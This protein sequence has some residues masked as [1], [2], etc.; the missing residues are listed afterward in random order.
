MNLSWTFDHYSDELKN[1]INAASSSNRNRALIFCAT[2]DEPHDTGSVYPADFDS[3]ISVCAANARGRRRAESR[4]TGDLMILGECI[5]ADGPS[6]FKQP[7]DLVS[8]SSVATALATGIASVLLVYAMC[9][10]PRE[11]D[12]QKFKERKMMLELF[13]RNMTSNQHNRDN[14]VDPYRLFGKKL[15]PGMERDWR[16]IFDLASYRGD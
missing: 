4:K 1:A 2:S 10:A 7:K 13:K 9:A 16:H 12:W 8:G 11:D 6:Y 3:T 14:Y 5:D 15:Q